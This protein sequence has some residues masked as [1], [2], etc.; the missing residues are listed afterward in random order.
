[1]IPFRI[2]KY[3]G[4]DNIQNGFGWHDKDLSNGF[5]EDN[6]HFYKYSH[7]LARYLNAEDTHCQKA[8]TMLENST[9]VMFCFII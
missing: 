1:M 5:R 3:N 9:I 2:F 8:K 4:K 7:N 6:I